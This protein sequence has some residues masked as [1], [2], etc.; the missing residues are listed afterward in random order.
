MSDAPLEFSEQRLHSLLSSSGR[1]SPRA[2]P[3]VRA[4][5][6]EVR[7]SLAS[8]G[9]RGPGE[10]AAPS[11]HCMCLTAAFLAPYPMLI[12]ILR[13]TACF[14]GNLS[15]CEEVEMGSLPPSKPLPSLP[16]P[17]GSQKAMWPVVPPRQ[18]GK[19]KWGVP[20]AVSLPWPWQSLN[21]V[22]QLPEP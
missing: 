8:P 2:C 15:E 3:M 5:G 20:T 6:W 9:M 4:S 1:A 11:A 16:P 12:T 13:V 21:L 10:V 19:G 22:S 17:Q 7:C 18:L 14:G